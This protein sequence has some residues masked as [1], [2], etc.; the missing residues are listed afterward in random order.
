MAFVHS[1]AEFLGWP[2]DN[3]FEDWDKV[4]LEAAKPAIATNATHDEDWDKVALEGLLVRI[5]DA[6]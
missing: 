6:G 5:F 4:A 2:F 3:G 1:V